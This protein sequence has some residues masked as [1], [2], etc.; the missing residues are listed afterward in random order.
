MSLAEKP[1]R[2][3]RSVDREKLIEAL[4]KVYAELGIEYDPTATAEQSR[5]MILADGVDPEERIFSR[6]IIEAREEKRS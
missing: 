2:K 4:R 6:G 3:P 5:A 1:E